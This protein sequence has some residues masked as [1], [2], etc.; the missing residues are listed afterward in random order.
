MVAEVVVM[1]V[2]VTALMTGAA[3]AVVAK[4]KLPEVVD[5]LAALAEMAA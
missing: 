5:W 1:P 3:A 4:V 2:A